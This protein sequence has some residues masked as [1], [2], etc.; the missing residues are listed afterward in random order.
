LVH[1]NQRVNREEAE[2]SAINSVQKRLSAIGASALLVGSFAILGAGAV[3]AHEGVAHPAHIHTGTCE[4]PGDVVFPLSDVSGENMVDGDA[5]AGDTVGSAAA[6]PIDVSIT[7]V[8]ASLADIVAADHAFVVHESAE[9]IGNYVLCGD[10]G[11]TM[12]GD[13][14]LAVALGELNDSGASGVAWLHDNGDG[15]TEVSLA[16]T[17]NEESHDMDGGDHDMDDM[18][19]PADEAAAGD[20]AVEISQFSFGDPIE[21]AVGTT[22]TWTNMDTAPHTVTQVGGEGFQSETIATGE[23]FSFTFTEAGSFEYFCEFHANMTGTVVV[24]G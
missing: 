24:T 10:I 11:G 2:L 7:T 14:D 18:G 1:G 20:V 8:A 16:V 21:V 22:V 6:L 19:T 3:T 15:T 17:M 23:S 4:A 9:N 5:M 12:I 13:S